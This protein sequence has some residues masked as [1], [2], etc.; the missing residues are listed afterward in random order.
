MA[1][2]DYNKK[3][4]FQET[5]EP[6]GKEKISSKKLKFVIQRHAA[7]RLHYDFRL[8]MDNVLKSWA[9]PKGPSL[10]PSDKRLAMMVE[11]HPYAYRTFEGTIPEGNYGAGEVEI[12]DEGT[13]EPI[14][15]IKGKTDDL[16]MRTELHKESLKFILHG[17]KLN[18]EFALVKIKNQKEDNAWLLIKHKDDF[19]VSVNYNAEEHTAAKSKV[20]AYLEKKSNKKK[21]FLPKV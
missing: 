2:E 8:E 3:R 5:S 19:S 11:D 15:K 13:Y 14:E 10:N 6:N 20:T 17:K 1:L 12:W 4:N 9:V 7:S 18:G 16:I 21:T